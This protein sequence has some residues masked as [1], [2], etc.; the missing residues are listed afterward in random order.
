MKGSGRLK[1]LI[2]MMREAWRP[3]DGVRNDCGDDSPG[4]RMPFIP[5]RWWE[6]AHRGIGSAGGGHA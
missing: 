6:M 2:R 1:K 4:L 5:P 3:M